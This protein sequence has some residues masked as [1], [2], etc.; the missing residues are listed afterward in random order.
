MLFVGPVVEV[1]KPV[2]VK[3]EVVSQLA[4][5]T[6]GAP[7]VAPVELQF[8]PAKNDNVATE[9]NKV[10]PSAP[11]L[12]MPVPATITNVPVPPVVVIVFKMLPAKFIVPAIKPVLLLP[13]KAKA[14]ALVA[15]FK[16]KVLPLSTT[17]SS[18]GEPEIVIVRVVVILDCNVKLVLLVTNN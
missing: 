4:K 10:L 14:T 2:I 17:K 7:V 11:K 8:D 18:P 1:V 5:G 13:E 15:L 16:F 12:I 9:P 6:G 3:F